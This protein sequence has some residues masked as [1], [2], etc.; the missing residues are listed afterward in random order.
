ML[1][2]GPGTG[3]LTQFL[4]ESHTAENV[5]LAEID[6][7]S[8]DYLRRELPEPQP[9]IVEGDFLRMDAAE[10]MPGDGQFC[11]IGNYPLQHIVADFFPRPRLER[12]RGVLQRH[13]AARGGPT[14]GGSGRLP[15]A[16]HTE[17]AAAGLVRC[18]I[19]LHVDET[20]SI[21][22]PR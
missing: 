18:G 10:L 5:T 7:E 12:P 21:L 16:W 11:I 15:N 19:S 2:I 4:L 6:T 9:R 13:A 8:V 20:C 14:A 3:V 1:E 22:R 17:R